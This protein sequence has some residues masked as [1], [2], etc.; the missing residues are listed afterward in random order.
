M[1]PI[2]LTYGFWAVLALA[3]MQDAWEL[4][5]SNAFPVALVALYATWVA[6]AGFETDIWQN[7]AVFVFALSAGLFLFA[8][9]WL[10]GGDVKLFA[11]AALWFDFHA[12]PYLL[13]SIVIAGAVLGATFIV[14][15]RLVPA[16]VQERTGWVTLRKKGPI[17]YG[18]AI[19]VGAIVCGQVYGFNPAGPAATPPPTSWP[20][21][22]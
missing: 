13:M 7:A 21:A 1:S 4:R 16:G 3:A 9:R 11:A 2:V 17:P 8:K 20:A 19:A 18:L 12:A 10:G 14:A 6:V 22:R 5:I 15:R